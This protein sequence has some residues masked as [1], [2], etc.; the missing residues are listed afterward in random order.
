MGRVGTVRFWEDGEAA[1]VMTG[2]I[3]EETSNSGRVFGSSAAM[4]IFLIGDKLRQ[5]T[6]K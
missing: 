4:V 3:G 1:A 2:A 5:P 6:L